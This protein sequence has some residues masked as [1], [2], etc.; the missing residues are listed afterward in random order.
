MSEDKKNRAESLLENLLVPAKNYID[1]ESV[2]EVKKI[3]RKYGAMKVDVKDGRLRVKEGSEGT[4]FEE[5][6]GGLTA[7]VSYDNTI[8][9][10]ADTCSNST[11]AL[12]RL[13][14]QIGEYMSML[15]EIRGVAPDMIS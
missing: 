7:H 8:N 13:Q 6:G 10:W 15:N 5:N 11:E 14:K 1:D 2:E 12:V 3:L 4:I 9:Y